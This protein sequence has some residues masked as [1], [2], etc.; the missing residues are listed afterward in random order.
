MTDS[1][2]TLEDE[3]RLNSPYHLHVFAESF[4]EDGDDA[5]DDDIS[6]I[7]Q[8]GDDFRLLQLNGDEWA[9]RLES[10]LTEAGV[11][12]F[13]EGLGLDPLGSATNTQLRGLLK[14]IRHK[15]DTLS[16]LDR[17]Q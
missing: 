10:R 7:G 8:I 15:Y 17:A 13:L 4:W 14:L 1:E 5:V 11:T 16:P 2:W 3:E 9:L 6:I 12:A